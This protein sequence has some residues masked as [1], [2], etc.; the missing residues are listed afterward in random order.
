MPTYAGRVSR[1][2]QTSKRHQNPQRTYRNES[3]PDKNKL[4]GSHSWQE[5]GFQSFQERI[6]SKQKTV[7]STAPA[8]GPMLDTLNKFPALG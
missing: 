2:M 8:L 7:N 5:H 1:D 4:I 6:L 3:H